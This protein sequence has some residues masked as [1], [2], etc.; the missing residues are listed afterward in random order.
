M[1]DSVI[2][3]MDGTILNT[4]DDLTESVNF[5]MSTFDFPTFTSNQV[6]YFVGNGVDML[7]KRAL[8][9]NV[10]SGKFKECVNLFKNHY[11]QNMY[12]HT[13]PYDGIV[14]VMKNLKSAN[15]RLGVVSNKFDN[16]VK[17]LS[18]KY[19]N[20]LIDV[21]IGQSEEIPPKPLPLGLLKCMKE[22]KSEKVLY[23]GDSDV[24]VQTAKNANVP[25][26]GVTWGLRDESYLKGADFIV[27]NPKEFMDIL[28]KN[29]S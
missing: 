10:D 24:D 8:P 27:G 23:V 6:K 20:N 21:S 14:D 7:F 12:N 3:D 9:K 11:A 22:L 16:A 29:I 13:K 4:L 5:V 28:F 18:K 2:F 19:F 17:E 15:I 25:V 26:V 1:I